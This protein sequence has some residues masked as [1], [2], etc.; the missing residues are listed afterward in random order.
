MSPETPTRSGP[1]AALSTHL[2]P[3][4]MTSLFSV[5][6]KIA[7]VTG[8]ASGLGFM[9][10]SALVEQGCVVYGVGRRVEKLEEAASKLSK[11]L[12]MYGL[13]RVLN[14]WPTDSGG[15]GRFVP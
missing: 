5:D 11:Y 6:S 1:A 15:R 10:A 8:A 7:V 12:S 14:H 4:T 13:P 2:P 9:I 3:T